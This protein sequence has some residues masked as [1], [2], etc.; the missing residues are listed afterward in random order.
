MAHSR[1]DNQAI[2]PGE[3][4]EGGDT[5]DTNAAHGGPYLAV[6]EFELSGRL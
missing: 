4:D 5:H 1:R 2:G 3:P 6:G